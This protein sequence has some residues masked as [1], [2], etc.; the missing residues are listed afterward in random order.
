[1]EMDYKREQRSI[2]KT[3]EAYVQFLTNRFENLYFVTVH[4]SCDVLNHKVRMYTKLRRHM[5]KKK[6]LNRN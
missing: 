1:M 5:K 2:L 6:K 4:E 3:C